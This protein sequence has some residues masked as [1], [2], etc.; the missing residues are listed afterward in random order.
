MWKYVGP[1]KNSYIRLEVF[2]YLCK[3][4]PQEVSLD[5]LVKV[6]SHSKVNL[7]GV[8]IGY[9]SRYAIEDS[10]VGLGLASHRVITVCKSGREA[11]VFLLTPQGL[12]FKNYIKGDSKLSQLML[13]SN[14]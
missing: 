10:L 3:A 8:A 14:V 9:E 1:L 7:L 12:E 11:H 4:Y 2:E 6:T 13:R 5:E